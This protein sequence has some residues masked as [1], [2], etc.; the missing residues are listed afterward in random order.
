MSSPGNDAYLVAT[1]RPT[2]HGNYKP[3]FLIPIRSPI[4]PM[5]SWAPRGVH[6]SWENT[7]D[8]IDNLSTQSRFVENDLK[9][10]THW[11]GYLKETFKRK[12]SD[13]G[14]QEHSDGEK[15]R[16]GS[17][18]RTYRSENSA[19]AYKLLRYYKTFEYTIYTCFHLC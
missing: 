3:M 16:L 13:N 19:K 8:G 5:T 2:M 11:V 15:S 1:S 6:S 7:D 12:E 14:I 17:N 18:A 9:P 10:N 4:S